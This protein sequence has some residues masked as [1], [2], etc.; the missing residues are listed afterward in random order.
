M[1]QVRIGP[2]SLANFGVILDLAGTRGE[3]VAGVVG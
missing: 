3:S 1:W 2:Q